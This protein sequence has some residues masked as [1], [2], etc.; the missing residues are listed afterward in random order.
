LKFLVD[1]MLGKLSRWLR[2]LGCDV[3]YYNYASDD[4]MLNTAMNEKRTLITRDAELFR[5]AYSK[6]IEAFFVDSKKSV[7]KLAE[8]AKYFGLKLE[9]D[10]S[11]SYCPICGG[12][13][14]NID[15]KLILHRIPLG[16]SKK[17]TKFW[18]CV[19][20]GKIYW[21]GRHLEQ[22][23]KTLEKAKLLKEKKFT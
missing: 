23:N 21:L 16:T 1:G 13:L 22:I 8:T 20:C 17:Y 6:G 4:M 3:K 5:R 11:V 9:V 14:S 2:I 15:R 7:D 12:S 19:D 10:M 18:I